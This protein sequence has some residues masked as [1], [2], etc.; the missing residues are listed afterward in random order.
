[1]NSHIILLFTK[2]D[3][4]ER[5]I[6]QIPIG[7]YFPDFTGKEHS[8]NDVKSYIEGQFLSLNRNPQ[9]TFQTIFASF[10]G[11]YNDLASVVLNAIVSQLSLGLDTSH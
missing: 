6:T 9:K 8:L 5:K 7:R 2:I 10:V 1:V 4:L 3:I 11:E